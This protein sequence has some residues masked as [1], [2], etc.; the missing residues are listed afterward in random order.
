MHPNLKR[1]KLHQNRKSGLDGASTFS[2]TAPSRPSPRA[3]RVTYAGHPP[4]KL[5]LEGQLGVLVV[6]SVIAL[7][8]QGG[9]P[10]VGVLLEAF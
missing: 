5:R 8:L 6:S 4:H 10:P 3:M 2:W 9:L 7:R 1:K